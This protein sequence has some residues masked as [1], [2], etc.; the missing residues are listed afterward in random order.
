MQNLPGFLREM[1]AE[2]FLAFGCGVHHLQVETALAGRASE[3][4]A[5][6]LRNS[7]IP[8]GFRCCLTRQKVVTSGARGNQLAD[9]MRP[10][11]V[12]HAVR[13]IRRII[14]FLEGKKG[15]VEAK[16][17]LRGNGCAI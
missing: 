8:T 1:N 9:D 5:D 17:K 7:S 14:A 6:I 13:R 12:A 2:L 4:N 10:K 16:P 11:D 3:V 15:A